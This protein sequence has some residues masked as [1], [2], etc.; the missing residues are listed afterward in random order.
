MLNSTIRKFCHGKHFE[1]EM[2]ILLLKSCWHYTLKII[3]SVIVIPF[4]ISFSYWLKEVE[5]IQHTHTQKHNN[6]L[7]F[8]KIV[9]ALS[10]CYLWIRQGQ[11]RKADRSRIKTDR[12]EKE[13]G[14][15]SVPSGLVASPPA[16]FGGRSGWSLTR[17]Q[18]QAGRWPA[19]HSESIWTQTPCPRLFLAPCPRTWNTENRTVSTPGEKTRQN[20]IFLWKNP[21]LR[22]V[23]SRYVVVCLMLFIKVLK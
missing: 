16:G 8:W 7:I 23:S 17:W 6:R 19:H 15:V 22:F 11:R 14:G 2:H 1:K 4:L 20:N 9:F 18:G 5:P 13:G 12:E 10:F 3:C 21:L